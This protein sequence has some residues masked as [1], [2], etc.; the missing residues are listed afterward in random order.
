[1]LE[2]VIGSL[3]HSFTDLLLDL[4]VDTDRS[5]PPFP[6]GTG[7]AVL[8]GGIDL[9][10]DLLSPL[11]EDFVVEERPQMLLCEL[12]CDLLSQLYLKFGVTAKKAI[13]RRAVERKVDFGR[14]GL[15]SRAGH[16]CLLLLKGHETGVFHE[17]SVIFPRIPGIL[18]GIKL[19]TLVAV[20]LHHR[21]S[22]SNMC[23]FFL[24]SACQVSRDHP[25]FRLPR[26][27]WPS[28]IHPFCSKR[29]TTSPA[30]SSRT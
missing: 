11:V 9:V 10:R 13:E 18:P 6:F 22:T 20:H 7:Q 14:V 29:Y 26:T 16:D 8:D 25:Y 3:L 27:G 15:T 17:K 2:H 19:E 30:I 4:G 21:P 12:V 23:G 1:L 24:Y 28:T 5:S